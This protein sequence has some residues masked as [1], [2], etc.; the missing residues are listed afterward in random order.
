M[1]RLSDIT[2]DAL[3][4]V[5]SRVGLS[6]TLHMYNS[7]KESRRMMMSL[8][9]KISD[10]VDFERCCRS[11]DVLSLFYDG[12]HGRRM[13]CSE[14]GFY[15]CLKI[16]FKASNVSFID[17]LIDYQLE[18]H[19]RAHGDGRSFLMECLRIA[20]SSSDLK[21]ARC[22]IDKTRGKIALDGVREVGLCIEHTCKSGNIPL[23]N[24][25]LN[26]ELWPFSVPFSRKLR[27]HGFI[28]ACHG[29]SVE[30]CDVIVESAPASEKQNLLDKGLWFSL[31]KAN[32]RL[33]TYFVDR[34]AFITDRDLLA[35]DPRKYATED[36][37][38]FVL[39]KVPR[40]APVVLIFAT[41]TRD[42]DLLR[43]LME[44]G[45]ADPACAWCFTDMDLTKA[46]EAAVLSG[47]TPDQ[48]HVRY[49]LSLGISTYDSAF[50]CAC[51]HLNISL[52]KHFMTLGVRLYSQ[53]LTALSVDPPCLNGRGRA[54]R[55]QLAELIMERAPEDVYF[56][57]ALSVAVEWSQY[58]MRDLILAKGRLNG[59]DLNEIMLTFSKNG[60]VKGIPKLI[61]LGA[62]NFDECLMDACTRANLQVVK[63]ML[64]NGAECVGDALLCLCT[65]SWIAVHPD[66][67]ASIAR[68]L[69]A[70]GTDTMD[71]ALDA[72]LE[73]LK[74]I[75]KQHR[76]T[77]DD[78][79]DACEITRMLIL[80]GAGD[81]T[82]EQRVLCRVIPG[83]Y[84]S[85]LDL[86]E[87]RS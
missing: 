22:V 27:Q 50:V 32:L 51:A 34:G 61:E 18:E 7:S 80:N 78:L 17:F 48:P 30:V 14:S 54:L 39:D 74:L 2:D 12:A 63:I 8:L 70:K 76:S 31:H 33:I 68:L 24:D 81:Y 55:L 53:A 13:I 19:I 26:P 82:H 42:N 73:E 77:G 43:F 11:G 84:L 6:Q 29:G 47:S 83:Y 25:L 71:A 16:A 21:V 75:K 23:L 87:C 86:E 20:F 60:Y 37:L 56:N 85:I 9:V 40:F 79:R 59:T 10:D 69:I 5:L 65:K 36:K 72:C 44:N 28:H 64:A 3:K 38:T 66:N 67:R 15:R 49:L 1:M 62:C 52:A 58:S 4:V 46:L 41:N 35:V 45:G 57:E